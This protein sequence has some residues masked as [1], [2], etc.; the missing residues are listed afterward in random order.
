[1]KRDVY[2]VRVIRVA[3]NGS[4]HHLVLLKIRVRERKQ[5]KKEKKN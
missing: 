5:V 3:E 2:D 1:M 4:D